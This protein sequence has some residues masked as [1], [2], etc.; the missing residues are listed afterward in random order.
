MRAS[1]FALALSLVACGS[2]EPPPASSEPAPA[3]THAAAPPLVGVVTREQVLATFPEWEAA[4]QKAT[5]DPAQALA[6]ARVPPGAR[7]DLYFGTWCPD[8]RRE[9]ARLWKAL[10]HAGSVPFTVRLIA[11][12]RQKHAPEVSPELNLQRV[13]TFV[14]LRGGHEVGRIVE[15]APADIETELGAL[16]RIDLARP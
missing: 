10:D 14:V 5:L 12:D 4:F 1:F 9:V 6:L 2:R 16:L 8:S 3:A 11:V 15:H 7:V 13:P